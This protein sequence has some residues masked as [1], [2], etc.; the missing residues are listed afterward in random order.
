[1][2]ICLHSLWQMIHG[3]HRH[4]APENTD[5]PQNNNKQLRNHFG[6]EKEKEKSNQH[7]HKDV[8]CA[9]VK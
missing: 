3:E 9:R 5:L 2:L 8:V 4:A 7:K 1:M 6:G